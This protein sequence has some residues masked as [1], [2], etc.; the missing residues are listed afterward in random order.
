MYIKYYIF[1][2]LIANRI[3][4]A[5]I[6]KFF[7]GFIDLYHISDKVVLNWIELPVPTDNVPSQSRRW[8]ERVK[9]VPIV[10]SGIRTREQHTASYSSVQHSKRL[11]TSTLFQHCVVLSW[12]NVVLGGPDSCAARRRSSAFCAPPARH[13]LHLYYSS[14]DSSLQRLTFDLHTR[15]GG[16]RQCWRHY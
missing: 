1:H 15:I 9:K 11:P 4:T 12:L 7:L 10:S 8:Q 2:L 3:Q 5:P 16:R 6:Q 14:R 13:D